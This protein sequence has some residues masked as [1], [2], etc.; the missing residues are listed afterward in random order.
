MRKLDESGSVGN[1]GL[2]DQRLALEWVQKNIMAFGGDPA[3]VMI[4]GCSAG[5]GSTANHAVNKHSWP[6]FSKA[7][8]ESGMFA[9]WNANTLATAESVYRQMANFTGCAGGMHSD[10]V[11][12]CLQG[13]SAADIIR[14]SALLPGLMLTI[15]RID[16]IVWAPV[17]DGVDTVGHPCTALP[18]IL[19]LSSSSCRN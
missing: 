13:K 19:F 3:N 12:S 15:P 16:K 9:M 14:A 5:A 2:Q 17:V 10:T 6:F 18:M 11:V 8:G 1:Y 4:D 7:A